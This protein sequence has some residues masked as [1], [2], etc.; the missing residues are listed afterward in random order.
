MKRKKKRGVVRLS[1]YL[2]LSMRTAVAQVKMKI[3]EMRSS[4]ESNNPTSPSK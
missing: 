3:V 2:S 1:E 4:P